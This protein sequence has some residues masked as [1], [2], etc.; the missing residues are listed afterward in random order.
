MKVTAEFHTN[1]MM[2]AQYTCDGA[3][4][5]PELTVGDI[6]EYAKSLVLIVDDPDAPAGIWDH[7]LLANIPVE[8]FVQTITQETFEKVILGQNSR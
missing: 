7:L 3:G 4:N 8:G 1:E 6:S 2:P 5:F